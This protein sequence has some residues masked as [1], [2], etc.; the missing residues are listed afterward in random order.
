MQLSNEKLV[1][2]GVKMVM[3]ELE[4]ADYDAAKTLL[5]E[6]GSVKRAVDSRQ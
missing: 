3:E 1:D 2:R 6:F 5:L 4:L